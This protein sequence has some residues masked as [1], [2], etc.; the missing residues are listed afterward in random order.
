MTPV[1]IIRNVITLA[2]RRSP[3]APTLVLEKMVRLQIA[4]AELQGSR[5]R[6]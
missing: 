3:G 2:R 1:Q 6:A 4:Q 5:A